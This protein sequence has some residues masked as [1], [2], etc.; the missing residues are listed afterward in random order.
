M[1]APKTSCLKCLLKM[2]ICLRSAGGVLSAWAALLQPLSASQRLRVG[3]LICSRGSHMG[4]VQT[5]QDR[6]LCSLSA[7]KQR[8]AVYKEGMLNILFEV[9]RCHNLG[10]ILKFWKISH[11]HKTNAFPPKAGSTIWLHPKSD[12]G[13]VP[14]LVNY[15]SPSFNP[16]VQEQKG[17]DHFVL[18]WNETHLWC[19]S[20]VTV[21]SCHVPAVSWSPRKA[22]QCNGWNL[23]G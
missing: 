2:E 18:C 13:G 1:P 21:Y 11:S 16:P 20:C 6:C 12:E 9:L 5:V 17:E 19:E 22:K 8:D 23:L 7:H 15:F 14:K 10:R 3:K 4:T